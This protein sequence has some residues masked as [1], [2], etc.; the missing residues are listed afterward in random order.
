MNPV[1]H[2]YG[3]KQVRLI[4]F[5]CDTLEDLPFMD[6]MPLERRTEVNELSNTIQQADVFVAENY[7]ASSSVSSAT[8]NERLPESMSSAEIRQIFRLW[9]TA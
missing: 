8:D 3:H 5:I 1:L 4:P 6:D 7:I 9:L 2:D